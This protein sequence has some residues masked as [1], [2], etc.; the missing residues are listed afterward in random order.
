MMLDICAQYPG[1]PDVRSLSAGEIRFFYNG[2]R[3]TLHELTKPA[4]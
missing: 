4:K 3:K 1:L 2:I